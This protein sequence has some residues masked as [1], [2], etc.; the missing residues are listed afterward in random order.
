MR[1]LYLVSCLTSTDT[2]WSIT[3]PLI[4]YHPDILCSLSSPLATLEFRPGLLPSSPTWTH[5]LQCTIPSSQT[6]LPCSHSNL[7]KVNHWTHLL[8]IL[9]SLLTLGWRPNNSAAYKDLKDFI[10]RPCLPQISCSRCPKGL[11]TWF[12]I[13]FL[14]LPSSKS[15]PHLGTPFYSLFLGNVFSSFNVNTHI[16]WKSFLNP[17]GGPGFL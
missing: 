16:L 2:I 8:K 5:W 3:K 11:V 17:H 15:F 4:F 12:I 9:H 7:S 13:Y 10:F 14:T 6:S 1:A